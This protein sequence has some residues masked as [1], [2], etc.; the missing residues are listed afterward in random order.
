MDETQNHCAA[1]ECHI[2]DDKN[3]E[4][5]ATTGGLV[6]QEVFYAASGRKAGRQ[7][8]LLLL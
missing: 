6:H 4:T 2:V 3:V 7:L 8:L 5:Y 1:V